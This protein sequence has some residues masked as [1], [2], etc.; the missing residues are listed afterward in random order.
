MHSFIDAYY[1]CGPSSHSVLN[2]LEKQT[3]V[4][5]PYLGLGQSNGAPQIKVPAQLLILF[6]PE[7]LP[8]LCQDFHENCSSPCEFLT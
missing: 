1:P 3:P 5:H 2:D 4:P 6:Y 7:V 8:S